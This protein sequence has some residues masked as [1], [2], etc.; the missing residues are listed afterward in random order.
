MQDSVYET[1]STSDGLTERS[2][3]IGPRQIEDAIKIFEDTSNRI[4]FS[5]IKSGIHYSISLE[6]GNKSADMRI[7]SLFMYPSPENKR[8]IATL[9]EEITNKIQKEAGNSSEHMLRE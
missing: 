7:K 9:I 1:K 6:K 2:V 8:R 4:E 3:K 5:D